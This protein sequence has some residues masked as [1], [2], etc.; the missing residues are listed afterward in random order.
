MVVKVLG[1]L[2][3]DGHLCKDLLLGVGLFRVQSLA[4]FTGQ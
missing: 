3:A 1:D 2:R 4:C